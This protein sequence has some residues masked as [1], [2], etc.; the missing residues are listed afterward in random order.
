VN[1]L[2]SRRGLLAWG[3]ALA[4][5][6]SFVAGPAA[7]TA[8]DATPAVIQVPLPAGCTVVASGLFN[9][10]GIALDADG[11]LYIAEAG[12]AGD[13]AVFASSGEG[14]PAATE[15]VTSYGLT[16]R[17]SKVTP[18]GTQSVVAGGLP[19]YTFG[20]EI[21]GPSGV[22]VA[23]GKL[24]VSVGGPGPLTAMAPPIP[25]RDSVVA[26]DPA[27][28]AL[29]TVADVGAY[30]R[31]TNPDPNA[32]DSNL[33]GIAAGANGLLYVADAGGNTVYTVDP[34]SGTLS[35]L[36]VVP[37]LP[38]PGGVAND[39]RSGK[40]EI[41]PVPTSVYPAPDGDLYVGLLSGAPFTPGSAKILH[42][43][44]D[45]TVSDAATGLTMVVGV[46]VGAD[47]TLYA[48]QISE[49]FLAQP[50]ALGSVVRIK[51]DGTPETV[52]PGLLLPYGLAVV[53]DGS[54]Y[55][56]IDAS[57]EPGTPP[58][59][60][61]LHCTV[62][63]TGGE[64]TTDEATPETA[65]TTAPAADVSIDLVDIAFNPKEITIPANQDVTIQLTAKGVAGHNFNID[66]L[67]IHSKNL[68]FNDTTTITINAPAGT[69]HYFGVMVN[70]GAG[71]IGG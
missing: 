16:G 48:S 30:E 45:G 22:A 5:G 49:N 50:P 19:S 28:G 33:G 41:D 1:H 70:G 63:A 27:T 71:E 66:Q 31:S 52:V 7:S 61:V 9:P 15:P 59:G 2:L 24:Y 14:T 8:Q 25:N 46:A 11:T 60:E 54:I 65:A 55:V 17:I 62:A 47:G 29:T 51:A 69:Y 53:G 56:A 67:N 35:V 13:E 34:A 12:D 18:D 64:T 38:S 6:A 37:G 68:L 44:P 21:V 42:I 58:Q 26:I 32:V 23:G 57:A 40:S 39:R 10:R 20:T 43:T 36:A 4:F 3:T